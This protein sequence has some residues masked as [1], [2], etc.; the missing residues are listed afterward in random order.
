LKSVVK[1]CDIF[2]TCFHG[3]CLLSGFF[4][5]LF[6]NCCLLLLTS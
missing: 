3:E 2:N 1:E 4:K 5:W 6:I